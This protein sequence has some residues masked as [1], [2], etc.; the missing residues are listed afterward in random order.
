MVGEASHAVVRE[1]KQAGAWIFGAGVLRQQASIVALARLGAAVIAPRLVPA[2]AA[3]G[4]PGVVPDVARSLARRRDACLY[5]AI[6]SISG[7]GS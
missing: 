4:S 1:I 6:A 7:D 2:E 3:G 5:S